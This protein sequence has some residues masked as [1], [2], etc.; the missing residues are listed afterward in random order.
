MVPLIAPHWEAVTPELQSLLGAL[1][2]L[3]ELHSFYLAGGTALGLRLGHRISQDLDFFAD[4]ES[5]GDELRYSIVARLAENYFVE[6][7]QDSILGLVLQ[8]GGQPVSFFTYGYALLAPPDIVNGVQI[9]GVID[10]G[11]MKLDA[12]AGRGTRKDFYDLYFIASLI[13]LEDLFARSPEKYPGAR[14]FAL[15]CG[16]WQRWSISVS[17]TSSKSPRCCNQLAG[18]RSRPSS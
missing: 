15:P 11:M 6:R 18:M 3:P 12:V 9:A 8:V 1:G 10:I 4:V 2:A 13:P 5:L 14:G 7:L 16:F 17:P